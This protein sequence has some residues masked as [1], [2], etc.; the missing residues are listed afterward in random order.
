M[1]FS[2]PL[3]VIAA[4]GTKSWCLFMAD[5]ANAFLAPYGVTEVQKTKRCAF[6]RDNNMT[7][8]VWLVS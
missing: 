2:E 8:G 5:I 4:L 6:H 1:V 3:A 7:C